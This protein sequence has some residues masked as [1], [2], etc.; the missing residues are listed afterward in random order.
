MRCFPSQCFFIYIVL[1]FSSFFFCVC[2]YVR[3]ALVYSWVAE[4]CSCSSMF[5]CF[6]FCLCFACVAKKKNRKQKP[7]KK[8]E[9]LNRIWI[10]LFVFQSCLNEK[11]VWKIFCKTMR[12][13]CEFEIRNTK[14]AINRNKNKANRQKQ[15]KSRRRRQAQKSHV[16]LP[17]VRACVC[18]SLRVC[19]RLSSWS[20]SSSSGL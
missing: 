3:F 15:N 17:T 1:L 20:S 9:N 6:C 12:A 4:C 11:S 13:R 5:L 2:F 16:K 19:A 7:K 8:L 10:F 18:V 14:C